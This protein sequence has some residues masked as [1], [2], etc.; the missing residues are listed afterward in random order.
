MSVVSQSSTSLLHHRIFRKMLMAYSSSSLGD[1][2]DVIAIQIMVVYYWQVTPLQLAWIPVVMALP[3][4]FFG[5]WAG[6]WAD[7]YSQVKLML[8]SDISIL[9]LT[10]LLLLISNYYVLL[11]LLGIRSLLAVVQIPAQQSLTRRIVKEEQLLQASSWNGIVKQSSKLVGP[12]IG[13]MIL[14]MTSFSVCIV[15]NMVMRLGSFLLLLSILKTNI[16]LKTVADATSNKP[17]SDSKLNENTWQALVEGWFFVKK[18]SLLLATL[19]FGFCGMLVIQMVDFQFASLFRVIA[20]DRPYL[21]GWMITAAGLGALITMSYKRKQKYIYYGKNL[22]GA[23]II[24]GAGILGM[25]LVT[26]GDIV[27]LIVIFCGL[28]LGVGNGLFIPIY[29]Y[30]LQK[31][32]SSTMTGRVFGIENMLSSIT[33]VIAPLLGGLWIQ[34]TDPSSVFSI[35]GIIVSLLGISGW[36]FSEKIWRQEID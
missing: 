6:V 32:T 8:I 15:V 30:I 28:L 24:I 35:L 7:R 20:P 5:S 25:G 16:S 18:Q 10:S 13:G 26:S 33:M 27:T 29:T 1:W 22:G 17:N 4:I 12:L 11:L 19:L 2:F 31:E 34:Y 3:G 14:S 21:L 23:Y 9:V 36:F